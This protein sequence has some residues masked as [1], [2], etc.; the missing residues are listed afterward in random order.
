MTEKKVETRNYY[1]TEFFEERKVL[2]IGA[3]LSLLLV[4]TIIGTVL[5]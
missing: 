4:I 2:G 5:L 1:L 3:G